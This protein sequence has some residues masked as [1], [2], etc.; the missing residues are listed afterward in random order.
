MVARWASRQWWQRKSVNSTTKCG[1]S[2]G[3]SVRPSPCS[4][5]RVKWIPSTGLSA[6]LRVGYLPPTCSNSILANSSSIL[7]SPNAPAPGSTSGSASAHSTA[8]PRKRYGSHAGNPS[9]VPDGTPSP[10]LSPAGAASPTSLALRV[11]PGDHRD[12][13]RSQRP[14]AVPP[15]APGGAG[16]G[17]PPPPRVGATRLGV[18]GALPRG[19]VVRDLSLGR[20]RR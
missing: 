11:G 12:P 8:S 15:R 18:P 9:P 3:P 1:A 16:R 10:P 7:G 5:P 6:R 17:R 20:C 4:L 14:A 13:A 19:V 2:S